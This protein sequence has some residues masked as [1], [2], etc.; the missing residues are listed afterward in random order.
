M[1]SCLTKNLLE[2]IKKNSTNVFKGLAS[3]LIPPIKIGT[4]EWNEKYR[5]LSSEE[6]ARPGRYRVS[7]TPALALPNGPFDAIDSEDYWKIIFQKSAQ[8]GYTS[9]IMGG[10]LARWMDND[11]S[12]IVVV[13]PTTDSAREYVAEKFRPMIDASPKLNQKINL[14]SRKAN[15]RQL[16]TKFQ[17]G[18]I[19]FVT[20]NSPRSVKSTSA[21][22]ILIEEPDDCSQDVKGQGG[23]IK[24]AEERLK[25]FPDWMKK[26]M[27]GGTP[28]IEGV[29][30]IAEHMEVTDKRYCYVPCHDCGEAHILSFD[31]FKCEEDPENEL[32]G[33]YD[34][35]TAY[36]VCPKCGSMW[37]F[38][39]KNKN[40]RKGW[41]Q[42]T[43]ESDGV[44]GF[45]FNELL[46]T[47]PDSDFPRLM[48]KWKLALKKFE[49]GDD[50]DLIVFTNSSMGLPYKYKNDLPEHSTL[51][52]RVESYKMR[53]VPTGV[54]FLTCGIDV[55][56]NGLHIQMKGWGI[57]EE[58]WT[59]EYKRIDGEN[60]DDEDNEI[61]TELREFLTYKYPRIDRQEPMMVEA[62]GIDSSDGT[63]SETI[64][65][66]VRKFRKSTKDFERINIMAV[67]GSSDTNLNREIFTVPK[68]IDHKNTKKRTTAAKYSLQIYSV[69]T[70]QAKNLILESRIN[71]LGSGAGRMHWPCD[72]PEYYFEELLGE[73]KV[74][75]KNN[76]K[77]LVWERKSS[78]R[79]E[80]LDTEVYCLHAARSLKSHID[81][82]HWVRWR[83]KYDNDEGREGITEEAD[84]GKN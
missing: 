70:H 53:E 41:W 78:V 58:S 77:R 16:F 79:N 12:A 56:H 65:K 22:R 54:Y 83:R 30:A 15:Q 43:Q 73:M 17:G 52:E 9:S 28:T 18:F 23:S 45:Y 26:I 31:N 7:L 63:M 19:K 75:S 5:I 47:F 62:V 40:V 66:V 32:Y 61:W 67:K 2:K 72:T 60:L 38:A 11:P 42:A 25:T 21:R 69:G 82:R 59:I 74:P 36:Y 80:A 1:K 46:S 10:A 37:S 35:S 34:P 13:F 71:L 49:D 50:S 68:K 81:G 84:Q 44:A 24:L 76:K 57:N 4:I 8:M 14:N 29:S 64:Y 39:Q 20:A 27:E 6:S 33:G 48:Q 51:M 55:Q 3:N